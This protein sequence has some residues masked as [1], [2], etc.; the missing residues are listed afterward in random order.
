MFNNLRVYP[1]KYA[2]FVGFLLLLPILV[3][4]QLSAPEVE[5]VYGGRIQAIA[6]AEV[7]SV[8]SLVY[9][10]TESANSVFYTTV[11][12]SSMPPVFGT[13][14][15][16]EDLNADDGFGGS[17]RQIAV[18][19]ASG[20][21]FALSNDQL[22]TG[23]PTPGTRTVL[24]SSGVRD[25]L[26][27]DGWL[28]YLKDPA[29]GATEMHFGTIDPVSGGFSEDAA[30]PLIVDST[31]LSPVPEARLQIDPHTGFLYVFI[32]GMPPRLYRSTDSYTSLTGSTTFS[33][34]NVSGLGSIYYYGAFGIG[35]DG[36]VFVGAVKDVEP[37]HEKFIG[38][39]DD[40]GASWDT[41]STGVGGTAGTNIVCSSLVDSIYYVYFGSA[42][43]TRCG[44][45]TTWYG[46]GYAG[47]ETHPNDGMVQV[48]PV[49]PAIIYLTTDQGIGASTN[50]GEAIFEI[51]DGVEAVQVN[52]FEMEGDKEI[53]WL[54]SK[55]GIRRVT[56]YSSGSKVWELFYPDGDGSPYF[57]VAMD[58]LHP[59][60]AY[61]GNV[62]VYK[63][64]D[65]GNTW[66]RVFTPQDSSYSFDFWSYISSIEVLQPY[67]DVVFVGIQSPSSGVPGGI[68]Y[69]EDG[70]STWKQVST[71]VYN[72]EV[73]DMLVVPVAGDTFDLF[74]GCEYVSD[75][76]TSSYGVK[77][78]RYVA[79]TGSVSFSNDMIG[80]SGGHI[81]NFGASDLA[82]NSA[83]DI[84][85]CG[86]NNSNEP[87]VY[88]LRRDSSFW[89]ALPT[90][91]LPPNGRCKAIT[92]GYDAAGNQVPYI[93]VESDIYYLDAAGTPWHLAYSYPVGMEINFLYWDDLL[94]GTGTG[95]YAQSVNMTGLSQS[96]EN[97][98]LPTH[99]RLAQNYPNP[100]NPG[101][102][103]EYALP[104]RSRIKLEVF[105]LLGQRVAVLVDQIQPA[106]VYRFR[107]QPDLP[108]GVYF[109]RL[110]AEPIGS[111]A[112]FR[113]IHKMI[114]LK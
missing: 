103:M 70:G 4:A 29:S 87:R 41:L 61:V 99:F 93:A 104:V 60:T 56:G 40:S 110:Q 88:V 72:P 114:L 85:A 84:F 24:V 90:A 35:P 14:Q 19:G 86:D 109:Y 30:S 31:L 39:T 94:V 25:V 45:D 22:L 107:W 97:A 80:E 46:M 81:T 62:R 16:I 33:A 38:Y 73:N 100:F 18:D 58:T 10:S 55:S 42:M 64:T 9:L 76:T 102:T 71:G 49:N 65:A 101:T 92:I 75:G 74:V 3:L 21:Y 15:A 7:D 2:A 11:D 52:D 91:G 20:T 17:I 57:S 8:T 112:P 89:E 67:P 59:D 43:S 48:D 34:L 12:H 79:S 26:A 36:R 50:R 66:M 63:T 37:N 13:F 98:H 44:E 32:S 95:L 105:N 51:D 77:T 68:F 5:A 96:D 113:Q 6:V 23:T 83:G 69:S 106:G 82:I 28:F 53:A 54:A 47:Q 108:G 1:R 27:Y 78:V 111:G